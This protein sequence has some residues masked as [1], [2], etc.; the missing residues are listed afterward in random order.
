LATQAAVV[1]FGSAATAFASSLSP[2]AFARSRAA[3]RAATNS[4]GGTP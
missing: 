2:A 3:L 1:G 4:S